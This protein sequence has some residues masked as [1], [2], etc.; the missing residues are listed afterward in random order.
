MVYFSCKKNNQEQHEWLTPGILATWVAEIGRISDRGQPGQIIRET[1]SPKSP[2][3][4]PVPPKKEKEWRSTYLLIFIYLCFWGRISL[5]S[6]GWPW[7]C[8]FPASGSWVLI[9]QVCI[10]T[11]LNEEFFTYWMK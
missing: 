8:S 3:Q 6:P 2:E 7:T 11:C 9:L 1:P 5:C 4:T 10:T